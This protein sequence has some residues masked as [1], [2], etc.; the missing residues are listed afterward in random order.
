MID[1]QS[2]SRRRFL[3]LSATLAGTGLASPWIVPRSVLARNG[4]PGANDRIIVG[5]VGT[6]GRAR[7]LMSHIPQERARIVA[8]S[9]FWRRKM[10]DAINDKKKQGGI[11]NVD[12]WRMYDSDLEMY[13]KEKLDCAFVV[14]QDFTRT[15]ASCRAV[16][17]GLDVYAEKALTTYISEGRTLVDFVRKH[18]RVFQVGSQQRSMRLNRFGCALI[19]EG[20]PGKIKL[21]LACNYPPPKPIPDGLKEEPI[22][23]GLDWDA[24]QGPTPARP[25]NRALLGWQQWNV[26]AGREMTN[27]G[28]HGVD[29]IQWALGMDESGPTELWPL[30]EGGNKIAMRYPNGVEVRFELDK[31]PMGGA[32]FRCEKGNLEI[33]RNKLTANPKELIDGAP[34][35]DPPEGPTWI[36]RPHIENFFDCMASREKPNAD[37]EIG[38]R[39][40]T[41]CH[42]ANITRELNRPLKWDP[43]KER[44]VDDDEANEKTDRPRRPGFE[45][46]S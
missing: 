28:A 23:E 38:H 44:F 46:P 5:F 15:T 30:P 37:V 8:V 19:R 14:T 7:Q 34:E 20:K 18:D 11:D 9:D 36:A 32:I 10:I 31:G 2:A 21:V 29:Q 42:L 4:A 40:V 25:F 6:G 17:A 26:Y 12:Q 22:P 16:A 35:P 27:W 3:G 1:K 41:V 24:W 43:V 39:S 33:N 13:D 45:L